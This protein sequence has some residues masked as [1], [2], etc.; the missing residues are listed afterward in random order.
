MARYEWGLLC[1]NAMVDSSSNNLS[2]IN[3]I[4]QINV[5][6]TPVVIPQRFFLVT[7]WTRERPITEEETVQYKISIQS[8]DTLGEPEFETMITMRI[9][10]DKEHIRN[11]CRL[12][13]LPIKSVGRLLIRIQQP[14]SGRPEE[15][16]DVGRVEVLIKTGAP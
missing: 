13:G 8:E 12:S 10:P 6:T 14:V 9:P 15:S 2:L 1:E 4:E 3:I 5:L 16:K 7:Y 11:L